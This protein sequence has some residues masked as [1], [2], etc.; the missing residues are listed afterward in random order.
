MPYNSNHNLNTGDLVKITRPD[1]S[2]IF[3]K[4]SSIGTLTNGVTDELTL[5]LITPR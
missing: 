5:N 1:G 2:I 3:I 4:I